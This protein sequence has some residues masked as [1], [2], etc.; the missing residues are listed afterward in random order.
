MCRVLA[1]HPGSITCRLV[2]ICMQDQKRE[3]CDLLSNFKVLPADRASMA[4]VLVD[5]PLR[6][7]WWVYERQDFCGHH[8]VKET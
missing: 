5:P 6:A 8:K 7:L 3:S 4:I 1:W 2:I